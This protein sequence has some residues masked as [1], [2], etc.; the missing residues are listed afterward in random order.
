M[1][2]EQTPAVGTRSIKATSTCNPKYWDR[3][4]TCPT[5]DRARASMIDAAQ[6][7]NAGRTKESTIDFTSEG[8]LAMCIIMEHYRAP[9]LSLDENQSVNDLRPTE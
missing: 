7:C 4:L 5:H 8:L 9:N 3:F 2:T 6:H 1:L